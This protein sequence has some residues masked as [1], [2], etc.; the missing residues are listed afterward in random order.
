[1][2]NTV[3][4][5]KSGKKLG[6]IGDRIVFENESVRVWIVSLEPGAKQPWHRHYLPYLI[7]A[8]TAGKSEIVFED[9]TVRRP[10]ESPGDVIWREPGEIHELINTADWK[11]QNIL[12]EIKQPGKPGAK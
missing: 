12:V 1:M 7:V 10:V 2:E 6:P 3:E 8:L 9:G 11:Y 4:V 5:S